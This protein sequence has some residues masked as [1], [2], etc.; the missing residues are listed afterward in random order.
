MH[1]ALNAQ[2]LSPTAGYRQAGV[3]G[4]IENLLKHLPAAGA[5]DDRWTVYAPPGVTR[6]AIG[7]NGQV[8]LRTARLPTTK[9][10]VR[11]WWEQTVA[12]AVLLRDRPDVVLCPLNVMPLATS[13]PAVVT[14][15]DLAFLR[16][17]MHRPAKRL[18]LAALTR[19]SARRARHIIAVSEFTRSEVLQ[20]LAVPP[21]RVTAI[22]NGRDERYRPQD[23]DAVERF[24]AAR[25]LPPRF[26]LSVATLEPRKNITT[27]VEAYARVRHRLNMQLLVAGGKGWLY[28]AIFERVRQ[29]GLEQQV[30]FLG[31]VPR[32]DL[33]LL[34]AAATAFVYP[35][36]YEGFG[37]PPL[38]ALQ[39]GTPTVVSDAGV[40]REVVGDAALVAP[41]QDAAALAAQLVRITCDD[42]L[43][44]ELRCR[45]FE[46]ARQFSW[47]RT[48]SQTLDVLRT[49][50]EDDPRMNANGRE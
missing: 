22:P 16:F 18:Y 41:A 23:S 12:P 39:T 31:F 7:A 38:E 25:E 4:Y 10:P 49:V 11:I 1:Y 33:P 50:G 43:R 48:A 37:F 19:L 46:R 20:L 29:L 17:R 47:Q 28:D 30:R 13:C 36:L 14:I 42:A 8:A 40:L 6:D 3:S 21:E 32:G 2:L 44:A 34:Y 26:L 15:H 9:P 35:S 45:G 24:R 27:L 5:P